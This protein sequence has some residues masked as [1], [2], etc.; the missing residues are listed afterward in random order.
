MNEYIVRKRIPVSKAKITKNG[1]SRYIYIIDKK[2]LV[3]YKE[4]NKDI[5]ER[6]LSLFEEHDH[7][8]NAGNFNLNKSITQ[9]NN[10]AHGFIKGKSAVTNAKEHIDFDVSISFDFK[11]FFESIKLTTNAFFLPDNIKSMCFINGFLPQGFPTSPTISNIVMANF[12]NQ[13]K[14]WVKYEALTK[15]ETETGTKRMVRIYEN[16]IYTRYADDITISAKFISPSNKRKKINDFACEAKKIVKTLSDELDIRINNKKTRLQNSNNGFRVITGV[17]VGCEKI[18]PT[19]KMKRKL[20]AAIH[21]GNYE[22]S[23]GIYNW[24]QHIMASNK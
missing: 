9:G 7:Y 20:R 15:T 21:Q 3:F 14:N 5:Q 22:E 11:N 8:K 18:K 10:P 17:S 2:S 23:I 16:I 4:L 13:M 1:K 24:C 6:Y 19:R 12:D